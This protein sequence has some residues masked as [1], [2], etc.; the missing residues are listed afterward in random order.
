MHSEGDEQV[1]L[2]EI[3][4]HSFADGF[5]GVDGFEVPFATRFIRRFIPR[6]SLRLAHIDAFADIE[7][8]APPRIWRKSAVATAEERVIS[9]EARLL[10]RRF[11]RVQQV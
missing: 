5:I 4:L 3:E 11:D 7:L 6:D 10:L 1:F 8:E 2:A 9:R